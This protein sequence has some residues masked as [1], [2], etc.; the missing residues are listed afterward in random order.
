[1]TKIKAILGY[2]WAMFA[3]FIVLATFMGNDYFSERLASATG[4][5]VSPWFSGAEVVHTV[6][7]GAY[8]TYIHRPVFDALIGEKK[9]GFMQLNWE[10]YAGL[11]SV[12]Q[13]AIDYN[14]DGKEDFLITLN[15]KT[16]DKSLISYNPTVRAIEG[17]YRLTKGWV[18]RVVLKK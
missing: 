14:G 15:T 9:E 7:H 3:V 18:I 12:V 4:I 16:G 2:I 17:P 11:P 1:M 6:D 8:K 10:P 13:E 5:K